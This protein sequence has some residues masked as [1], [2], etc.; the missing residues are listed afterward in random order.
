MSVQRPAAVLV[1]AAGEGTRMKSKTP[2]VLHEICG[3]ALVDHVL[4]AAGALDPERLIVVI[5]HGRE[6]V[7]DH[8][9]AEWPEARHVVQEKPNGTGHAVRTVLEAE[10]PITGT[11]I[12]TCGDTPLLRT[13]T[14]A[15]LLERHQREGNAV[16][17]LTAEVPDPTGYGRIVRGPGGAVLRIVE[18]KDATPEER[19]IREV[20]SGV[21]A[22][23]GAVLA[24]ALRRVG[25]ANAQGEEYLT[26]AVA[27][28]REDGLR[29]GAHV[30]GDHQEIEGVNDRVQL[31]AARRILNDR[32]LRAHMRAGVTIVDPAT[33]WIDAGV[34]LEPDVVLHP[35]TQ[36]KGTTSVATGA[37]IGPWCTLTDTV[38]GEG[39]V[40]RNAVCEQAVIGPE[41]SVG[42]FAYLRPGTVLG[43]KGKIGTYVETKNAKIG[44]GSKVPHLTYVGDATI[45]VGSNIGASTVFVNYDGVNKHHTVVGDHVRV[46]SD[47]MLVAPVTIGDGA[48]TAAGSVITQDVP[49]GAMAVARSR[50]R[51]IEGW[52]R[53]RRPGTPSDEA[54]QRA[55]LARGQREDGAGEGAGSSEQ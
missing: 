26:D 25:T 40:V 51:N 53:R 11:I 13:E 19:A 12:V 1:L 52:V 42:P 41:A 32:I 18:E 24:D 16:T 5:G 44:E 17:V 8:L 49:P 43:R 29:V 28:L 50:Q 30:A 48:Y 7:A 36:L 34:T 10:G 9:A 27:I 14:L 4:A 33:T 23:D 2:K 45:G 38:V 20:N 55:L 47:T 39:A 37:Q 31:A 46:G 6:Q 54:A 35:G 3:R 22:F 15:G 21:Y